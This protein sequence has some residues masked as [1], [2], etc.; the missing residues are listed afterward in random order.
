MRHPFLAL[1][2]IRLFFRIGGF[3]GRAA[4]RFGR[5]GG[6]LFRHLRRLLGLAFGKALAL[7]LGRRR[8]GRD[9]FH[10][11]GHGRG[12]LLGVEARTFLRPGQVDIA[13]AHGFGPLEV[14]RFRID[15]TQAHEDQA[16]LFLG[17]VEAA[18]HE[19][20]VVALDFA[21][22][23]LVF[24]RLALAGRLLQLGVR[25][26]HGQGRGHLRCADLIQCR[27]TLVRAGG[28]RQDQAQRRTQLV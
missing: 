2:G 14:I 6:G 4:R 10:G 1:N 3:T 13:Q 19:K 20:L 16:A 22:G 26:F 23:K 15:G 9:H 5:I 7:R 8:L 25:F 17:L 27:G 24:R 12:P 21:R 28:Q 11:L 18:I